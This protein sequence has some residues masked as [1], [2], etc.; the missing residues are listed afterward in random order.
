MENSMRGMVEQEVVHAL[1]DT[2]FI[3]AWS[4]NI[5]LVKF[6]VDHFIKKIP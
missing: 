2:C 5:A 6:E 1:G 4:F 3:S